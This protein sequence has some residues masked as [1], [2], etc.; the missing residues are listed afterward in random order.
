MLTRRVA[1][2]K[3]SWELVQGGFRAWEANVGDHG[4][5]QHR[6]LTYFAGPFLF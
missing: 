1:L 5:P 6:S 4:P 2:F 3:Q